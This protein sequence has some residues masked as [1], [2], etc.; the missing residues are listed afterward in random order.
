MTRLSLAFETRHSRTRMAMLKF[1]LARDRFL[2][3]QLRRAHSGIPF[4]LYRAPDGNPI[5]CWLTPL[6]L[7][8]HTLVLGA[9]GTG[10]SSLL[11]AM[12]RLNFIRRQGLA[13]VDL[14][15]DLYQRAARWAAHH[16]ARDLTLL[17]FTRPETLPGW[18]PLAPMPGVAPGRQVDLLVGVL[19]RLY[20]S[21]KAASWAWGVAVES[22]A[23]HALAACIESRYPATLV[24]VRRFFL[25]PGLRREILATASPETVSFFKTRFGPREAMYVSA[26]LNKLDPFLASPA[27]ERFLGQRDASVDLFR[28]ADEGGTLLINLAKGYLGPSAEV[29]GRLLMNVL[30]LAALRRERQRPDRRVPLSIIID[31]AQTLAAPDSGLEDL[32][33]AAR[34]YRVFVTLAAQGLSL[35]PPRFRPHLLG[36][37]G[38]QFFFRMPF[39]EA[40]ALSHDIFE[41]TGT[42]PRELVRAYDK[43]DDPMLTPPEEIA[44]RTREL[45]NLPV[46]ACYWLLKG[47]R[48]RARRIQVKRPTPA[49]DT[50]D[51]AERVSEANTQFQ[52]SHIFIP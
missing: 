48:F 23:R 51:V 12:A 37:T 40:Q 35:F 24:D 26:L 19:R 36:N 46:G 28:L 33:V 52:R 11:E 13:L 16:N 47:R 17:D 4:A 32:L 8:Q 49:P 18:N 14:H 20:A 29:M 43:I 9:T 31:E 34:K 50:F 27:V 3:E 1:Y 10:K 6:D 30:Q 45:S 21:E 44:A 7:R 5:D 39:A 42:V 38:R 15:G 25:M 22:L 41:A 2:S